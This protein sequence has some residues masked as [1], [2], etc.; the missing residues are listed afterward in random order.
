MTSQEVEHL[1][2]RAQEMLDDYVQHEKFDF[3]LKVLGEHDWQ[4]DLLQ[5]VAVPDREGV[6]ADEYVEALLA[7]ERKLCRKENANVVLVPALVD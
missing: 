1:K 2:Q 6:P 5:L 7:V 3:Y 4:D